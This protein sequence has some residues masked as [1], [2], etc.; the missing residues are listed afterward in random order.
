MYVIDSSIGQP[1]AFNQSF[2]V[3]VVVV[4]VPNINDDNS[5]GGGTFSA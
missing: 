5:K 2:D 4:I 1:H 3:G